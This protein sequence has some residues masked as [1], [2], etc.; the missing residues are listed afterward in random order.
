MDYEWR[1]LEVD[2]HPAAVPR[3]HLPPAEDCLLRLNPT[4]QNLHYHWPVHRIS[5]EFI[6]TQ[7]QA[8]F[9]L[10]YRNFEHRV[11][12]MEINAVTSALL[13]LLQEGPKS[14]QQLLDMLAENLPQI[15]RS[16]LL[17][18]GQPLLHQLLMQNVLL[19]G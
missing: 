4:L 13:Q 15:P 7:P 1:E 3:V 8:T 6:P 9:L 10:V 5:P 12:F 19:I 11:Q 14:S 18:F 16:S 2:Q 17:E